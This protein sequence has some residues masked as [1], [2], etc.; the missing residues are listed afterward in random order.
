M[1]SF[2]GHES[3]AVARKSLEPFC[4][5]TLNGETTSI[6]AEARS[7]GVSNIAG[8]IGLKSHQIGI[9]LVYIC[10][11]YVKHGTMDDSE[12]LK[13]CRGVGP[14]CIYC[15]WG[16]GGTIRLLANSFSYQ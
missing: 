8:Y 3:N 4:Y 11:M 5:E 1:V 6:M 14:E 7:E 10:A 15:S 9:K 2:W 16:S 13:L 12:K